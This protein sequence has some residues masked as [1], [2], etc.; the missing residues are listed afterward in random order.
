MAVI[1]V[2]CRFY[3]VSHY[4]G[5]RRSAKYPCRY[6]H[7]SLDICI[8]LFWFVF[9][10]EINNTRFSVE[11]DKTDTKC[12]ASCQLGRILGELRSCPH[13]SGYFLIRNFF[14]LFGSKIFTS[15]RI[16]IQMDL[17]VHVYPDPV[18]VL[19]LL[20]LEHEPPACELASR[21]ATAFR[22]VAMLNIY[23]LKTGFEFETH[24]S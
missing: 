9:A 19:L 20:S 11:Q 10:D 18:F 13:L 15:T 21:E 24:L 1:I 4:C 2:K 8:L 22:L 14:F 17:P 7:V 6:G 5:V 3:N 16:Q 12:L 23:A